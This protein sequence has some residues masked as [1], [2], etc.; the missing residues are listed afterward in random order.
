MDKSPA[1]QVR[2]CFTKPSRLAISTDPSIHN[3]AIL[4]NND[5]E[6]C[7]MLTRI[8]ATKS[9]RNVRN[10][11]GFANNALGIEISSR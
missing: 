11:Y 9:N 2:S 8:S 7:S 10:V 6:K 5:L 1:S 4:E 3:P